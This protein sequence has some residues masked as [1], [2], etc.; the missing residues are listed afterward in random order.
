MAHNSLRDC[1]IMKWEADGSPQSV[2]YN[3]VLDWAMECDSDFERR[4]LNPAPAFRKY[5]KARHPLLKSYLKRM[6]FRF[7]TV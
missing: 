5:L 1:I 2:Q 3:R 7:T 6:H 4:G